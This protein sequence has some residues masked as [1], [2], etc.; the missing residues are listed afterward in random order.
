M[1]RLQSGISRKPIDPKRKVNG[2]LLHGLVI[3]TYVTDSDEHPQAEAPKEASPVAVYCDVL[4]MPNISGQRWFGLKNVLVSQEIAGLHRGRIWKPRPTKLDFVD[5]LN[6]QDG[7]NPAYADGDHVLVGF[8]NDNFSQPIILRSLPH[9]TGDLGRE[10]YDVGT[11]IKLKVADGDPDFF[12]HHGVHYGVDDSGDFI[13]DTTFGNDGI[14]AN[15]GKEQ[16][17]SADGSSGNQILNLPKDSKLTINLMDMSTPGTPD[18]KVIIEISD[19]EGLVDIKDASGKWHMK[20]E[21]GE[22]ITIE[23]K[24]AA[25]KLT[26]GDGAVKVAVADHLQILYESLKTKLDLHDAHTH[27]Y[28][29]SPTA[30]P[31]PTIGADSWDSNI[32]SSKL[33]IPD[34]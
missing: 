23:G 15:T 1:S 22:S 14:L 4:V 10:N 32:N 8:M 12:R 33:T 16:L 13:L 27:L 6:I 20:I 2:L 30:G 29:G 28:S 5:V 17:P 34:T 18:P 11:R 7:I 21:E 9:P 26:L 24:D 19:T 25:A 3:E 31:I